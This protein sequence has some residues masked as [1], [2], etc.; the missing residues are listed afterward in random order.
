M[1][2]ELQKIGITHVLNAAFGNKLYH[3]NTGPEFYKSGI[4]FHGIPAIDSYTFKIDRYFDEASDFIGQAV[5][6]KKTRKQNEKIFVHCKEGF[7]RSAVLVLAYLVRDHE[8][9]LKEAVRHVRSKREI[10]P[11]R[12]FLKQL[13]IFS[14]QLG[15]A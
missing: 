9:H 8:M 2:S 3:V 10:C 14:S 4:V 15:R 11:N 13:I 7:S 12:S 1:E 5:G 6:T